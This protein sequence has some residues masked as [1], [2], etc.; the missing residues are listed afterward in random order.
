[1]DNEADELELRRLVKS[2][3][4]DDSLM[5]TWRRYNLTQAV[6]HEEAVAP[7][8]PEFSQK[9][10]AALDQEPAYKGAAP[11]ASG[12]FSQW[13]QSL[14][15]VAIAASVAFA[16]VLV[17]Q[18]GNDPAVP[19]LVQEESTENASGE[20]SGEVVLVAD[21]ASTEL[22]PVAQERLRDYI[23][24]ISDDTDVVD[25]TDPL[26]ELEDSPLLRPVNEIEDNN[27]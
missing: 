5:E 3:D 10:F 20:Q 7:V 4:Q 17:L 27:Q 13:G 2:M 12:F 8:N 11:L 25:E 6:L 26:V 18:T 21:D 23:Q 14:T 19:N 9:V 24:G 22:D 16:V 15:K 1:M